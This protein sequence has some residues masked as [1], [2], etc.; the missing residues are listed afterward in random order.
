MKVS[1]NVII[2]LLC[3]I[4]TYSSLKANDES[5]KIITTI[6]NN[7][8]PGYLLIGPTYTAMGLMD[9]YGNSIDTLAFSKLGNG[10]DLNLQ[11]NGM[12]SFFSIENG[13]HYTL[14]NKYQV[15]DSF[16][17]PN[18]YGFDFHE[19]VINPDG[20]YFLFGIDKRVVNM[21]KIISGGH[22]NAEVIGGVILEF[23]KNKNLIWTWSSWDNVNITDATPDVD[24][25]NNVIDYFHINSIFK[26]EIDGNIIISIR[27]LDEVAKISHSTGKFLWRM[28]GTF[29]KNNQFTF[30]NDTYQG[31]TGFSHQHDARRLP[32]GNLLLLDNGNLKDKPFSR[33]VEYQIDESNK[34]ATK[35]WEFT[36]S[37]YPLIPAMGSCQRLPN[38]NTFISFNTRLYEVDPNNKVVYSGVLGN[39]SYTYKAYKYVYNMAAVSKNIS[40]TGNYNYNDNN[41][42]T[43]INLELLKIS[44]SGRLTI[45][46]HNYKPS[47]TPFVEYLPSKILNYRWVISGKINSIAG[48]LR[49]NT[50][51]LNGFDEKDTFLIYIRDGENSGYFNKLNTTYNASTK[52]LEASINK[53][54]ELLIANNKSLP[55]SAPFLKYPSTES[56]FKNDSNLIW[57]STLGADKY[58]IQISKIS[59]FSLNLIDTFVTQLSYIFNNYENGNKYFWRL[60]A[61]NIEFDYFSPW[62][63]IWS[64]RTFIKTPFPIAPLDKSTRLSYIMGRLKWSFVKYAQN[65]ALEISEDSTFASKTIALA[66]LVDTSYLYQTLKPFTDY[67]WRVAAINGD[68]YTDWSS[69]SMFQTAVTIPEL[70]SPANK[71]VGVELTGIF[72]YTKSNESESFEY[73]LSRFYD[74]SIIDKS[75]IDNRLQNTKFTD[76]LSYTKYFWRVRAIHENDTSEWSEIY[77]FTTQITVPK[78]IYPSNYS[79]N[80]M[81]IVNF[82][83]DIINGSNNYEFYLSESVDFNQSQT[84]SSI[85]NKLLITNLKSLQ[86]YYWKVRAVYNGGS[87]NWSEVWK[88]KTAPSPSLDKPILLLPNNSTIDLATNVEL[89]WL[90]VLKADNYRVQ[91]SKN[92]NFD[93]MNQDSLIQSTDLL[94]LN[95][96]TET[97]YYWRVQAQ[98]KDAVSLWSE[99]RNFT[100]GG[101]SIPNFPI[102]LSPRNNEII[103]D[104]IVKFVWHSINNAIEYGLVVS[105]DYNFTV[106]TQ[107]FYNL[108]D[109]TFEL[110]LNSNKIYFWKIYSK[111][112]KMKSL[113]SPINKFTIENNLSVVN[114]FENLNIEVY[115]NPVIDFLSIRFNETNINSNVVIYDIIGN[116]IKLVNNNKSGIMNINC[117]DLLV[118]VYTL[119]ISNNSFSHIY[120]FTKN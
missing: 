42:N 37:D 101:K 118:G 29:C 51:D 45:E 95:L 75:G 43:N 80:E 70:I 14:D 65:Y 92:S 83:W 24:L 4:L 73:Q 76:L 11:S 100:I 6:L 106:N 105:E 22:E 93:G 49:I 36:P 48:K 53:S 114:I 58:R 33:V 26:D 94:L 1:T 55:S 88:F 111:T 78:L 90:E 31:F 54:G 98:S 112:S 19:F 69:V 74:F 62:S 86:D 30:V 9:N 28:G 113:D 32:N 25:T 91:V 12:L 2:N 64:F 39:D 77:Q 85:S 17:V 16:S 107:E 50:Q 103:K 61:Y 13:K 27:Y 47:I 57:K 44:N 38:G 68:G 15:V 34:K 87:S 35:I 117:T 104:S 109:T 79:I 84:Y 10:V 21:S 115:P 82:K 60:C 116:Q 7:P 99:V 89:T 71:S 63:D 59:D 18:N 120:Y 46:K 96:E 52:T 108:I 20:S 67:Y 5:P 41:N 102:T 8:E 119:V 3:I 66:N 97:T 56:L 23:D 81:Q 72:D 40:K 110:K